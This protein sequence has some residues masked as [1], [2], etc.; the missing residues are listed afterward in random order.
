MCG[1]AGF[2][3]FYNSNGN[4]STLEKMGDAIRH[5][6]PDAS[7]TY[8]NDDV[9]FCHQRL[10]IIDLSDSGNQPMFSENK[11]YAIIFNGEIYNFPELRKELQT[12]GYKFH[13]Q[14]DTEVILALYQ[15]Y[16]YESLH[17]L[18]GMFDRFLAVGH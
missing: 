17:K 18:N 9:G 7:G 1:I 13:S 3:R 14:T 10:S 15:E 16:G 11:S 6:G 4:I 5:R 8:L 2:T 12:K